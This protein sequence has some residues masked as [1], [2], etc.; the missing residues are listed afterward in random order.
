MTVSATA[1]TAACANPGAPLR[2]SYVYPDFLVQFDDSPPPR[3]LF[4]HIFECR[5]QFIERDERGDLV[6]F[7]RFQ[8][9]GEA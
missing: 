4:Q 6:Q 1:L 9:A 5:R 2:A 3:L 7:R 8:I